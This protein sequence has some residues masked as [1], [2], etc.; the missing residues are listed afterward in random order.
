MILDGEKAVMDYLETNIAKIVGTGNDTI[1]IYRYKFPDDA[2]NEAIC[3][4]AELPGNDRDVP[5]LMPVGIRITVRTTMPEDSFT[6]IQNIDKVI[7]K[8]SNINLSD[9]INCCLSNRNS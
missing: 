2:G 4:Y 8:L 6:L 9:T 1:S 5:E 3:V 7:D